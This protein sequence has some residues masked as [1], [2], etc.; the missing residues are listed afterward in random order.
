[1]AKGTGFM[2]LNLPHYGIGCG[3]KFAVSGII[4]LLLVVVVVVL[5]QGWL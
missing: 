1:M 4:L 5:G 2:P 3:A